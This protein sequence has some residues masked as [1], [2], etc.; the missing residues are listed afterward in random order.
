M[1][2]TLT[3][4]RS[5]LAIGLRRDRVMIP[6]WIYG[7]AAVVVA[8]AFSYKSLYSTVAS[9]LEFSAVVNAN[10]STVAFYGHVYSPGTLGG[11]VAWRTLGS[12]AAISCVLSVLLVVRHSRAEEETGRLELLGACAVGRHAA[13]ASALLTAAIAQVSLAVVCVVGLVVAGLP[14]AGSVAFGAAWLTSTLFFAAVAG[15]TAQL[16][17]SSRT[18]NVL[19]LGLL[20]VTYLLRAVGDAGPTWLSWLS[21]VS[22][23]QQVR[24]YAG[25]RWWVVVVAAVA[26]ALVTAVAFRFSSQR[27]LGA[28]LL[29]TPLGPPEATRRLA[30]PLALAWRLQRA[31]VASWLLAFVVYGATLGGI[32]DGVGALVRSSGSTRRII[33]EMGGRH[34]LVDAFLATAMGILGF[35]AA[36]FVVQVLLRLR[37]EETAQRAE[38]VLATSV[39]RVGWA[40]SH[41]VI[42]LLGA[43]VMLAVGGLAAA[44]T[45]GSRIHDLG[46]Q[47]PSLL[48]AALVQLPAVLILAGAVVLLFGAAPR[49]V[50]AGAWTLLG[51]S[52]LLG[53]FGPALQIPGW[54][55]DVSPFT[56]LP[57]LPGGAVD[58]WSLLALSLL[59]VALGAGGMVGFARRDVG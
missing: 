23:G 21:P 32:A 25:D 56:H 28:G 30:S 4:T 50:V 2:S 40:A 44:F 10:A 55:M 14:V 36:A 58:G 20:G 18:A 1:A 16:S 31:A 24:P 26:T 7:L 15:V 46:G 48:G 11:L 53:L 5:L 47:L 6:V 54:A 51:F 43:V 17:E 57:K 41:L 33:L 3:N 27:D 19:A 39:S 34:G 45:H 35:L 8:S 59:A 49:A 42:A 37:V 9:R 12:G 29:P 22:W 38:A 13:L 52:L